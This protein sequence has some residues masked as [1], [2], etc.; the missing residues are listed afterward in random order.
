GHPKS[1]AGAVYPVDVG[2][3]ASD[4]QGLL[5]D[6]SEVF[7]KEK[8]NVTGVHSQSVSDSGGK[9]AWM[10]FTV[11]VADASRLQQVMGHV[12]R[13]PGVRNARRK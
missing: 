12:A 10:T 6:I 8:M 9:T 4:R 1:E 2:V 3:E 7:A 13:I 11:E 5:R